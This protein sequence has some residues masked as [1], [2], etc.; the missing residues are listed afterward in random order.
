MADVS[1]I[2][3]IVKTTDLLMPV[4]M[5][6]IALTFW[7]A[8]PCTLGARILA[9]LTFAALVWGAL[10]V[11]YPPLAA[12]RLAPPPGGQALAILGVVLTFIAVRFTKPVKAYWQTARLE[13]LV[14]NGPWRFVYGSALFARGLSDGLPDQFVWSAAAG[15]IAVGLWAITILVRGAQVTRS[16]IL[17]WNILGALDLFHVLI[18]G[19]IFLRP[20]YLANPEISL[21]N[22]L[23]L[24]G[25]P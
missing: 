21:L 15:D 2:G 1:L 8:N 20:F 19:A 25:V 9:G 13:T 6:S 3:A 24:A 7:R 23:P 17:G 10:W 5:A 12:I 22:L 14:W 11:W 4:T 16:E 18:L